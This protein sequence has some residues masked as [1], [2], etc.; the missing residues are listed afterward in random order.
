MIKLSKKVDYGLIAIRHIAHEEVDQTVNA[1]HI[2]EEY[3][4]PPE[5]LAKILQKL[6]R[7]GLIS[8]HNGPK[9]GYVLAK[10]PREITI[11]EIIKAIE[12]P[13]SLVDCYS[14]HDCAQMETCTVR[15]PID[16]IQQSINRL[17]DS[18]TVEEIMQNPGNPLVQSP[19]LSA[20]QKPQGV[21]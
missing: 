2:A 5:L 9:G 11:G 3:H 17:L 15:S 14:G 19:T 6:A 1:K 10:D 7:G 21:S 20:T 18:I 4:I 13:V 8:G 12:G 16:K